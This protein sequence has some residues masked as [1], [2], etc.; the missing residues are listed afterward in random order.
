MEAGIGNRTT[1]ALGGLAYPGLG[2]RSA[3]TS[4]TQPPSVTLPALT[5]GCLQASTRT[6]STTRW[7]LGPGWWAPHRARS[8]TAPAGRPTAPPTAAAWGSCPS[9]AT[10]S[11]SHA[12]RGVLLPVGPVFT[13]LSCSIFSANV[14]NGGARGPQHRGRHR[15]VPL[16]S[17]AQEAAVRAQVHH[18]LQAEDRQPAPRRY[19]GPGHP[20]QP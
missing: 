20:R 8:P 4:G 19:G 13:R 7:W 6:A 17:G 1:C 9:T 10:D 18:L 16:R 12:A 11:V 14:R 3:H 15:G 2:R 5:V